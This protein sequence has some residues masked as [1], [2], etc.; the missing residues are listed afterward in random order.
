[1]RPREWSR[2][3]AKEKSMST[4]NN[5]PSFRIYR[6]TG[7]GDD[8]KWISVGAAWSHK[9][10]K[11]YNL[12]FDGIPIIGRVVLREPLVREPEEAIE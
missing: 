6:V 2:A 5:K 7:E 1:M 8:A 11:G 9:D 3:Q 12:E 4:N 10:G